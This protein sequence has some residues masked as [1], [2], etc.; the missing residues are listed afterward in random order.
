[1]Y[2]ILDYLE[3]NA[4]KFPNKIAYADQIR[5]ITFSELVESGKKL[6]SI[7]IESGRINSPVIIFLEKSV[8]AIISLVGVLYSGNHYVFIDTTMPEERFEK[9]KETLDEPLIISRD[10][11]GQKLKT[12]YMDLSGIEDKKTNEQELSQIRENMV[13][14]NPMYIL[15][16]SGST[17]VPKGVVVSHKACL[18][19]LDWLANE[20]EYDEKTI[21]GNQTQLHF[22]MSLSDVIVTLKTASTT[23]LIPKL[24]FAF[25]IKMVEMLKKYKVNT[26]YWVP[27]ALGLIRKLDVLKENKISTIKKILFAGE[28]M[29]IKTLNYLRKHYPEN[30]FANLFGP[31]E[32]VDICTFYKVDRDFKD[33][34]ILPI[35]KICKN[36][37]G[38]ILNE[39]NQL[40]EEGEL[41]ISGSFLANGY[42]RDEL[43]TARTFIQNPLNA[44]FSET[45]YRTGDIVRKN[46]RGELEF[47]TRKDFQIKRHG[48][49][50]ELGEIEAA[51]SSQSEVDAVGV[52]Y[53]E[54]NDLII[55][56]YEGKVEDKVLFEWA[57]TKLQSYMLPDRIE[58]IPRMPYNANGKIDR[59]KLKEF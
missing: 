14:I 58:K 38:Y 3:K 54:K 32:T 15:F 30:L 56:F 41:C 40:A 23:V 21:F 45:I 39:E 43:K 4:E 7:I 26:I 18:S 33:E 47:V 28:P 46:S 50:I 2:T 13:D 44:C 12:N 57:K 37:N 20:F 5:E 55:A 27:S 59:K 42:Y 51:I 11:E 29:S 36:L 17:G 22:S 25:P 16:T 35:G 10:K 34:E 1:M 19:Y 52:I 9:I 6:G 48:Y 53:D 24:F 31:S 49:R 8:E